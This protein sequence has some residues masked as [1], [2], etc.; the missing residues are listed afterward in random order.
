MTLTTTSPLSNVTYEWDNNATTNAIEVNADGT[1]TLTV[2]D[3]HKCAATKSVTVKKRA[4]GISKSS[5]ADIAVYPN[6]AR[7]I[8]N[9]DFNGM[10]TK[11]S[12]I[13]I[14]NASGQII[15][16]SK[17]TSDIM[18]INVDDWAQGLYFIKV[19]SNHESRI[20]KFVKE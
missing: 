19:T 4:T 17:Q 15:F 7:D 13:L 11:G 5:I 18:Q 9:I 10:M 3:S 16:A 12:Q 8:V 20:M 1:H 6:P 2:T 14:A